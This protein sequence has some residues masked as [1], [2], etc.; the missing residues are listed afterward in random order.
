MQLILTL[1]RAR[2]IDKIS[3]IKGNGSEHKDSEFPHLF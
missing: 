3:I 1:M 2:L